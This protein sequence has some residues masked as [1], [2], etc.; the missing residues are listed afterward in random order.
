MSKVIRH[1]NK[2]AFKQVCNPLVTWLWRSCFYIEQSAVPK[3][4]VGASGL[5]KGSFKVWVDEKNLTGY[6]GIM[7]LGTGLL[8]KYAKWV[9]YGT[10][11]HF[12]S[13]KGKPDLVRWAKRKGILHMSKKGY[14]FTYIARKNR[15][16]RKR[17]IIG[18]I[19][20][21]GRAQP[22]LRPAIEQNIGRI[23]SELMGL[24]ASA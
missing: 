7:S 11:P 5:L 2:D 15:Q 13:F 10:R 12:V 16:S 1:Y 21:S 14:Y 20:V 24:K 19:F 4:P 22:Y 18:G 8:P 9:E 23:R 6:V 3:I 17:I